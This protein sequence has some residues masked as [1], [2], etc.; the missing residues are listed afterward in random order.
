M[1]RG[2][3]WLPLL[4]LF[5][6]LAWAGWNEYRKLEAYK[7]WAIDFERAKYD[8]Y[9]ALG[10]NGDQLTWGLPTRQGVIE[11]KVL[12]LS[13]VEQVMMEV[14]HQAV[15]PNRLP[16]K[17]R[18]SLGFTLRGDRY[19]SIPF[20]DGDIAKRWYDFLRKTWSL[21]SSYS[22]KGSAHK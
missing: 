4:G 18:F 16:T 14:D 6:W 22:A 1:V 17:G 19:A 5:S 11:T 12:R 7:V 13:D 15:D 3:M 8:I 9:A 20:T 2:L 10:Q 21:P